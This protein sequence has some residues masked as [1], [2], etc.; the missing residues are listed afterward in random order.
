MS[1]TSNTGATPPAPAAAAPQAAPQPA[2]TPTAQEVRQKGFDFLKCAEKAGAD[3]K[4]MV[5]HDLGLIEAEE[6]KNPFVSGL[7]VG[8]IVA[9]LVIAAIY[10]LSVR[11]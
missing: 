9:T 4:A 2:P 1:D 11:H 10:G 3:V 8:A 6:K 7:L 5:L